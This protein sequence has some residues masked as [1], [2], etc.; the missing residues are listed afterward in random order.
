[1]TAETVKRTVKHI[2]VLILRFFN[3]NPPQ[4]V[5]IEGLG[6]LFD[7]DTLLRQPQGDAVARH[8]ADHWLVGSDTFVKGEC[9]SPAVCMFETDSASERH[10]PFRRIQ[11]IDGVIKGDNT[12]LVMFREG[13]GWYSLLG[14]QMWSRVRLV[15]PEPNTRVR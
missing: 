1:L 8:I 9:C 4:T 2:T 3:E 10:G 11:I 15:Q 13:R 7:R 5:Q 12:P 14:E 6:F